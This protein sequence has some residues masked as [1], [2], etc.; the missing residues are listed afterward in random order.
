MVK[1]SKRFYFEDG[2][3]WG[4]ME[5]GGQ[6]YGDTSLINKNIKANLFHL[7]FYFFRCSLMSDMFF[8]YKL[9]LCFVAKD[10]FSCSLLLFLITATLGDIK[11]QR[12]RKH[13]LSVC[14]GLRLVLMYF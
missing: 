8:R 4:G 12:M 3:C 7:Q 14:L 9:F 6:G 11:S 10:S 1:Y 13:S 2:L 5:S